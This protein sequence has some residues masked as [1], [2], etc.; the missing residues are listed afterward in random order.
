MHTTKVED[1]SSSSR[2]EGWNYTTRH[3]SKERSLQL[4]S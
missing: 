3:W 1:S 2:Q 4:H